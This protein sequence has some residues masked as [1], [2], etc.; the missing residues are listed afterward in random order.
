MRDKHRHAST[1]R[2]KVTL[3][4]L[5]PPALTPQG[6]AAFKKGNYTLALMFYTTSISAHPE[7]YRAW[8]NRSIT[9]IQMK[10]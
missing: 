10:R 9:H 1:A 7:D 6:N 5:A 2:D 8:S 4:L 3:P